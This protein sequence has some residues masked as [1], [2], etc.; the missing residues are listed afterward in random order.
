MKKSETILYRA[1]DAH[2]HFREQYQK[3]KRAVELAGKSQSTL[4]PKSNTQHPSLPAQPSPALQSLPDKSCSA[5]PNPHSNQDSFNTAFILGAM[6]N[7]K[8]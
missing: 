1:L 7:T 3:L 6:R 8:A 2:P 4:H 5:Q